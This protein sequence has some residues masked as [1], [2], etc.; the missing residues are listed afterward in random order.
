MNSKKSLY[1]DITEF[2][3][4]KKKKQKKKLKTIFF[5]AFKHFISMIFQINPTLSSVLLEY[6]KTG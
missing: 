4:I 2:N 1:Y 5:D 3:K 6:L